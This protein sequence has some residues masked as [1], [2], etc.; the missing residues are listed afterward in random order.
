MLIFF[1]LFMDNNYTTA[2]NYSLVL[3]YSIITVCVCVV[4]PPLLSMYFMSFE[5]LH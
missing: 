1:I 3:A 2:S 4:M 5:I